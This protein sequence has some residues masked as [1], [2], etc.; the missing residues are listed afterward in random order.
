MIERRFIKKIQNMFF[1]RQIKTE[2]LIFKKLKSQYQRTIIEILT[3]VY[4]ISKKDVKKLQKLIIILPDKAYLY[5]YMSEIYSPYC[6]EKEEISIKINNLKK[7]IFSDKVVESPIK[8]ICEDIWKAT[9]TNTKHLR[10]WEYRYPFPMRE[11]T[12]TRGIVNVEK[13]QTNRFLFFS[14]PSSEPRV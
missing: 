3:I 9:L 5:F 6:P 10:K 14:T 4:S 1:E 8:K 2:D 12:F 13:C 7:S 11:P